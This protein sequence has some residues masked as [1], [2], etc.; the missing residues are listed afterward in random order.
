MGSPW[1][2]VGICDSNLTLAPTGGTSVLPGLAVVSGPVV[3]AAQSDWGNPASLHDTP[4]IVAST[5]ADY[6]S[7][8]HWATGDARAPPIGDP[9]RVTARLGQSAFILEPP[10]P[11]SLNHE[12]SSL[13]AS[14]SWHNVCLC[15]LATFVG[16]DHEKQQTSAG[17]PQDEISTPAPAP[18]Y[19]D[20]PL[21][22]PK[23][24]NVAESMLKLQAA[25][26]ELD[27]AHDES[28]RELFEEALRTD[29]ANVGAHVNYGFH[30]IQ[31]L[32]P[33]LA[34]RHFRLALLLDADQPFA[35]AGEGAARQAMGDDA[36][37]R[38][39][40][41]A[42]LARAEID[43]VPAYRALTHAAYARSLA[44]AARHDAAVL[45]FERAITV[46]RADRVR[47]G[48]RSLYASML[49]D[50]GRWQDA[51]SQLRQAVA[52]HPEHL[53]SHYL[54]QR[55]H[56]KL[57]QDHLARREAEI[58]EIL[59]RLVDHPSRRFREDHEQRIALKKKLIEAYPEHTRAR[60]QLVRE[61]L[62]LKRYDEA[63]MEIDLEEKQRGKSG[64]THFLLAR[65]HA[66]K[67]DLAAARGYL[68]T[69]R[70]HRSDLPVGIVHDVLGEW[71]RTRPEVT[72]EQYQSLFEEWSAPWD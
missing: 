15:L 2:E 38:P 41:E 30:L 44:A 22:A 1:G 59:R 62:D 3:P 24:G 57:G 51:L 49:C 32:E 5:A 8:I 36:R 26:R 64:E 16:C 9:T 47:A 68:W 28:A 67:G 33:A 72:E 46:E 4:D 39:L 53:R 34:L 18:S 52:E 27:A 43:S 61:Y 14:L 58:H 12:G 40:L 48:Y 60:L 70:A 21:E 25:M 42:A 55:V 23:P 63:L 71:R 10:V 19:V 29:P 13:S 37:A 45:Q 20:E 11:M 7:T 31:R 50:L 54:L 69:M 66:G 65:A 56:Q 35:R 17:E 6:R